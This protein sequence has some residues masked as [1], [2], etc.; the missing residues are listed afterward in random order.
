[1]RYL[2][3]LFLLLTTDVVYANDLLDNKDDD[4]FNY[5]RM[6][7][8]DVVNSAIDQ[9]IPD[10]IDSVLGAMAKPFNQ[11]IM[12]LTTGLAIFFG[13]KMFVE[14][15]HTGKLSQQY[16]TVWIAPRVLLAL[17][18]VVP[19]TSGFNYAQIAVINVATAGIDSANK[20]AIAAV[21]QMQ[22]TGT[23][24]KLSSN[25]NYQKHVI[26]ML[27]SKVCAYG[28]N[29]V[30]HHENIIAEDIITK[31]KNNVVVRYSGAYSNY[32]QALTASTA[33]ISSM[34]YDL[35][36]F[37]VSNEPCG[38]YRV[39]FSNELDRE[40]S[41]N[42]I[43][44]QYLTDFADLL[45][46]LDEDINRLAVDL[47]NS[48]LDDTN[49][50]ID[51]LTQIVERFEIRHRSILDDVGR[52]AY[53]IYTQDSEFSPEN[54]VREYGWIHFGALYWRWT[55]ITQKTH[56][57]AKEVTIETNASVDSAIINNKDMYP[58]FAKLANFLLYEDR[59]RAISYTPLAVPGQTAQDAGQA[60]QNQVTQAHA[61]AQ[62]EIDNAKHQLE[63]L[64]NQLLTTLVDI[65]SDPLTQTI[66]VG[67][68]LIFYASA[69]KAI[70]VVIDI[71]KLTLEDAKAS[72]QN[73]AINFIS[74][75]SAGVGMSA[76][77]NT[78]IVAID[79]LKEM[80]SAVIITSFMF[81]LVAAYL[82]P[83]IPLVLWLMGVI[84]HFALVIEAVLVAPVIAL[85]HVT[86]GGKGLVNDMVKPAYLLILGLFLRPTLM[87]FGMISG[88]ILCMI[89][90]L[91]AFSLWA[92]IF[93][94]LMQTK[95][96]WLAQFAITAIFLVVMISVVT[97]TFALINEV[98]DRVL[99]YIGGGAE[100]S[101][102]EAAAGK[103]ESNFNVIGGAIAK[104]ATTEANHSVQDR[105]E[106]NSE[107]SQNKQNKSLS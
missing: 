4:S 78:A 84:G 26:N 14:A 98:P 47:V 60:L 65:E 5:L 87:C 33:A 8:G 39:T 21:D 42:V 41:F 101:G 1:M 61:E 80:I 63:Q 83:V 105:T 30:T 24:V 58:I 92:P 57:L 6:I 48:G 13:L 7:F 103:S 35:P 56:Q 31:S 81:A 11:S 85:L 44:D 49:V 50:N 32:Q 86:L 96:S 59:Y 102:T 43:R 51:R 71:A 3:L 104:G 40:D 9:K 37:F 20:V 106:E 22:K 89:G 55:Q 95:S 77:V 52:G 67:H 62:K 27:Q 97:R 15:A 46:E 90:G 12:L 18:F 53:E 64:D 66:T 34:S 94:D 10:D 82:I 28:F 70:K 99:K 74:G 38:S 73:G 75:G 19:T 79:N 93:S 69:A 25:V 76:L 36:T 23:T 68:E 2:F 91:I 45:G 29:A 100:S 54:S 16:D 107:Q 88:L 72:F 17:A